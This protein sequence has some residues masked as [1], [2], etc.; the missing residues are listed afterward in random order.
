MEISCQVMSE[1]QQTDT[2]IP[3]VTSRIFN[4]KAEYGTSKSY[5]GYWNLFNRDIHI[6]R[7][8][9]NKGLVTMYLKNIQEFSYFPRITITPSQT[10]SAGR[11]TMIDLNFAISKA[12]SSKNY[13]FTRA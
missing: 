2:N 7:P 6:Y 10:L 5:A 3:Q 1:S 12:F 8:A 11:L 13:I 9:V 4:H